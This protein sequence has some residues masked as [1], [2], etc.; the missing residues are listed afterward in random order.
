MGNGKVLGVLLKEI[1]R[2][3]VDLCYGE[4]CKCVI[5]MY[6][7]KIELVKLN[8]EIIIYYVSY[9]IN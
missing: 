9:V 1:I 4:F 5:I 7:I 2:Y 6:W 8:I 3:M